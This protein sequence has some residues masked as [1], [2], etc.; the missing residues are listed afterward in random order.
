MLRPA[1]TP[2]IPLGIDDFRK[3]RELGLE[4]VDK[5]HLIVE[6][7]DRPGVEVLLLPRPRRFGKTLNLSMLRYFFE[8]SAEDLSRLFEG[9]RVWQAGESYRAHFQRY[10]VVFISLKGTRADRAEVCLGNIQQK[11]RSAYYEHRLLLEQGR[12]DEWEQADF[13]AILDGTASEALFRSSLA[14]LTGYLHR[15]HGQRAVVLIDEYDEPIH[16]AYLQGYAPP[17]LDFFRGWMIEGLKGNPHLE[18]GVLTGIL[19]VA[20]ESI[21]SGLNN[22]GV[23]TLLHKDFSTCFGFTEPEVKELL[24]SAGVPE[25]LGSVRAYYNGYAFGGEA[26]YNPWS[27]L[28]FLA[29]PEKELSPHWVATSSNELVQELLERHAFAIRRDMEALLDGGSIEKKLDESVT[30]GQLRDTPETI[31]PLLVFSGY[32][33]AERGPVTVAQER[34]PDRLSIP[35]REVAEVYRTVFRSWMDRGLLSQGGSM[36]GLLEALLEGAAEALERQMQAL[37]AYLLSYHDVT[38]SDPERFYHGLMVGLL[39]ALEPDYEVRSNRESGEGRPDVLIKPRR[40]CRPGVVLEL[41]AARPKDKTLAR[42]LT[43]G[44]AQLRRGNYA[45]EL[46]AAGVEQ[47]HAFAIAFDGKQVRVR[48]AQVGKMVRKVRKKN[49]PARTRRATKKNR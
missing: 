10:P 29:S 41:K 45:A 25:A 9:L 15:A 21:F 30:L 22:L 39:A 24:R 12:L 33:R 43:E 18:R 27:I 49:A 26:I 7:L 37:A 8:R 20:K 31:W 36:R 28:S 32:L 6:V 46:H 1:M 13:R 4:Y 34:P 11:I 14:K 19:R 40:P 38:A 3:L 23:Y 48:Q 5:S 42:A 35:N 16:A 2:R 47:V 44:L 17:I